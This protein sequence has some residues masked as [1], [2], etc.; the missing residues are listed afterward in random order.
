MPR[1]TTTPCTKCKE[2]R[3]YKNY[4]CR[5]CFDEEIRWQTDTANIVNNYIHPLSGGE[6]SSEL[7]ALR[8]FITDRRDRLAKIYDGERKARAA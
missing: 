6:Y 3:Q 2:R 1:L 8:K 7:D 4:L 5:R